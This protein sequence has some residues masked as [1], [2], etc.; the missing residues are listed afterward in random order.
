MLGSWVYLHHNPWITAEGT[1]L[2]LNGWRLS[3]P[4]YCRG[5]AFGQVVVCLQESRSHT[6]LR[7]RLEAE[8][9]G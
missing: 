8:R 9:E 7:Q 3:P 6:K 5:L 1:N 4:I 2:V